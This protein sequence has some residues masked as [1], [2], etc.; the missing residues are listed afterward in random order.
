M[1]T[2]AARLHKSPT[3]KSNKNRPKKPQPKR[4]TDAARRGFTQT[5]GKSGQTETNGMDSASTV[6]PGQM[7]P[8]QAKQ[9]LE[10]QKSEEKAMIFLPPEKAKATKR[11]FKDW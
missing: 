6:L 10:A 11:V 5:R 9:L 4:K 2:K 8:E 7:T 3:I 1:T